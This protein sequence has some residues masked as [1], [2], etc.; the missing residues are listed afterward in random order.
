MTEFNLNSRDG[1][2]QMEN[3]NQQL[4]EIWKQK[5]T[6]VLFLKS[7]KDPLLARFP[8]GKYDRK[9]VKGDHRRAPEWLENYKCWKTPKAWL[10]CLIKRSLEEYGKVYLIQPFQP[11]QKCAPACW[12]ATGEECQCSCLGKNHGA[13]KPKG[14][15]YEVSETFAVFWGEKH[16]GCRLIT[17]H[18][19][20]GIL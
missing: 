17:P 6:P 16:Y 13:G 10:S 7:K 3:R 2:L 1:M 18:E 4:L 19:E 20:R 15:W 5:E 12:N 9:W 11:H 8:H 14:K